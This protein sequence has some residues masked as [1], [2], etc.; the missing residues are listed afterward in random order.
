M[1]KVKVLSLAA[2]M[3]SLSLTNTSCVGSFSL[4]NKVLDWNQNLGN[5]FV[6]ELVF[7]VFL[8]VP[9]YGIAGFI[10][11]VV[12]NSIEFW[13]GSNPVAMKEGESETQL[14]KGDDGNNYSI[15]ASK[16]RFDVK[17]LDGNA[18]GREYALVFD[19]EAAEWRFEEGAQEIKLAS[20]NE[21]TAEYSVYYP[22]G[23]ELTIA[24]GTDLNTAKAMIQDQSTFFASK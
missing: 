11:I 19:A 16:N 12:L 8:I 21:E 17:Q 10:D 3:F 23:T 14:V 7:L 20:Y 6:N 4:F 22:D 2:L 1:K 24:A 9:V 13:T 18:A 5:K 15:T